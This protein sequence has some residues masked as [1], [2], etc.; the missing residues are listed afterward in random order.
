VKAYKHK[1]GFNDAPCEVQLR[2]CVVGTLE[3]NYEQLSCR[4]WDTSYIDR[5]NNYPSFDAGYSEEKMEWIRAIRQSETQYPPE[6]GN[7]L[8]SATLDKILRILDS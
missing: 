4:H 5:L 2:T 6:Y 3:G 8:D 7:T 1:N